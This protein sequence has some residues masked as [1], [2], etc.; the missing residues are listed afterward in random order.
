MDQA[1]FDALQWNDGNA[2]VYSMRTTHSTR[3]LTGARTRSFGVQD[4]GDTRWAGRNMQM[5]KQLQVHGSLEDTIES[6]CHPGDEDGIE[7]GMYLHD[8]VEVVVED[9]SHWRWL[10]FLL[11]YTDI[12]LTPF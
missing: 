4:P 10:K 7:F 3:T 11:N 9:V 12:A 6:N 1:S 8:D 2:V 5:K